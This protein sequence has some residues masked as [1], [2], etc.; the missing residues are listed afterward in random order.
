MGNGSTSPVTIRLLANAAIEALTDEAEA[1]GL[2]SLEASSQTQD[3]DGPTAAE[4]IT[5]PKAADIGTFSRSAAADTEH[6]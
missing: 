5:A 4:D 2:L 3:T 1:G 6:T